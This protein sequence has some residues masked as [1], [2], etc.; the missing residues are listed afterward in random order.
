MYGAVVAGVVTGIATL[1]Q[2]AM[3][4]LIVHRGVGETV[5]ISELSPLFLVLVAAVL[6][7]AL[8]QG[9][10]TRMA[11]RCSEHVRCDARRQI[12]QHWNAAGPVA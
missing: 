8:G 4:A 12:H 10:Q 6:V 3:L 2:M 1:V 9:M 5:P 7:R 11:A